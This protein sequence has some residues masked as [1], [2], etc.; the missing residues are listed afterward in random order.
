MFVD[1]RI[2]KT[3]SKLSEEDKMRLRY[4]KEQ[5][6]QMRVTKVTRKRAKYNLDDDLDGDNEMFMGFTHHGKRLEE[7]DDFKDLMPGSS[8]DEGND[9]P[10]DQDKGKLNEEI[11]HK[12]NFGGGDMD[13]GDDTKKSRKEVFEEII[14]KSKA[15]KMASFELKQAAHDLTNK[16]DN[17]FMDL[18]PLL[19]MSRVKTTTIVDSKMDKSYEQIAYKL[20]EQERVL[21]TQAL[22]TDREQAR[23]KK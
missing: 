4:M 11:V 18:L 10:Y 21:P 22:M 7:M 23:I 20:K 8:D 13:Y 12:M 5:K 19:N 9:D 17:Q 3:T 2:G 6:D 1:N 15:Y 16:L 14:A